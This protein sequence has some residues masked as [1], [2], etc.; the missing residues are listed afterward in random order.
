MPEHLKPASE[1]ISEVVRSNIELMRR[2]ENEYLERRT[3]AERIADAI[4]DFT[5]SLRFVVI[6]AVWFFL[7]IAVNVGWVPF[8]PAFDK[9]P[10]LLLSV[11]VSIEAIFLSTFVLIKQNRMSGRAEHRAQIDLQINLLAEKEMTLVLQ[12]LHRMSARL[13]V[14]PGGM[15]IEELSEETPVEALASELRDSLEGQ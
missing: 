15:Q 8:I 11:T 7:W 9:F 14:R 12:L 10:F 4:A 2:L 13:G 5:G 1:S 3:R 6:H